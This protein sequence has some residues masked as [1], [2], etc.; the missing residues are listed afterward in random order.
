MPLHQEPFSEL[1]IDVHERESDSYMGRQDED[2][3]GADQDF[4]PEQGEEFDVTNRLDYIEAQ[5]CTDAPNFHDEN[6][7]IL[8]PIPTVE[9]EDMF[10]K[11]RQ[12]RFT[13]ARFEG[14]PQHQKKESKPED[15]FQK[16]R[17]ARFSQARSEISA[18]RA[19][20]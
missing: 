8:S 20:E 1:K 9:P 5:T 2:F 6:V 19:C 13:E 15:M 11:T 12:A 18:H 10:K 3:I 4:V 17:Q 14:R 16:T 7:E